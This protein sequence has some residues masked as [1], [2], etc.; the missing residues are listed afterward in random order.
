MQTF[1]KHLVPKPKCSVPATAWLNNTSV[2]K[3][4]ELGAGDGEF[5]FQR[6]KARPDIHFIAIEKTRVQFNLLNKRYQKNPLPNLWIFNTNAV[7]WVAHFAKAKS[8]NKVYILYPNPYIKARQKNLRWF[9]RP[10]MSYLWE[11]LKPGG[12]IEFRTNRPGYYEECRQKMSFYPFQEK[13]QDICLKPNPLVA[14]TRFE[15]KYMARGMPCWSLIYTK[16]QKI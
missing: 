7:W 12:Q 14:Q 9:N 1:K 2:I 5:A 8:L 10:F 13:S 16:K 6:A 4:L 11:C 15:R 3:E